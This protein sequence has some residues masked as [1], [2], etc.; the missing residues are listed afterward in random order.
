MPHMYILMIRSFES[1]RLCLWARSSIVSI[2]RLHLSYD[3]DTCLFFVCYFARN[4]H[5]YFRSCG[6][7]WH[8]FLL[9]CGWE[10]LHCVHVHHH[11]YQFNCASTISL[12]SSLGYCTLG[13]QNHRV[14]HLF[15]FFL[16]YS[17]CI[18]DPS[19]VQTGDTNW[20]RLQGW[21]SSPNQG[22]CRE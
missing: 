3:T 13:G 9:L 14:T 19:P 21:D 10:I 16:Q 1:V 12:I 5:L 22:G 18:L 6:L 11:L 17:G 4:D 15:F 7:P 2:F 20:L 8:Y